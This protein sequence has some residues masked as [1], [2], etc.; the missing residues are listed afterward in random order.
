MI[1]AHYHP[2][3]MIANGGVLVVIVVVLGV[4]LRNL[5]QYIKT[6]DERKEGLLVI[7]ENLCH[8]RQDA[9]GEHMQTRIEAVGAKLTGKIEKVESQACAACRKIDGVVRSRE[10][11]WEAQEEL[12]R[13]LLTKKNP[14]DA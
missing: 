8:E 5:L 13:E 1:P 3:L 14:A 6:W 10:T 11:K 9:C 12:N 2:H 7:F 4:L